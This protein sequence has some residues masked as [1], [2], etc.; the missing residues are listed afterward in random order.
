LQFYAE[1]MQCEYEM[2]RTVYRLYNDVNLH[3]TS[4]MTPTDQRL[5]SLQLFDILQV[6]LQALVV[7][8]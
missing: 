1:V 3:V 4:S 6:G 8:A 7:Y 5:H 2:T